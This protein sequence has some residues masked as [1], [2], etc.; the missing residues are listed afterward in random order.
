MG[1]G[2]IERSRGGRGLRVPSS[3]TNLNDDATTRETRTRERASPARTRGDAP[4]LYSSSCL[5]S[6]SP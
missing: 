2:R 4:A 5:C 3:R 1:N 6:V